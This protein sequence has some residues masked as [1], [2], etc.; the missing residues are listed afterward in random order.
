MRLEISPELRGK[1]TNATGRAV[2]VAGG[3]GMGISAALTGVG[4]EVIQR[5][6]PEILTKAADLIVK[7][8]SLAKSADYRPGTIIGFAGAGL[9][10]AGELIREKVQGKNKQS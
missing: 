6:N 1:L 2:Q 9:I 3:V 5:V 4:Q 10:A 7:C 8:P